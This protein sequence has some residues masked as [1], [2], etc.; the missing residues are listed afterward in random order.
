MAARP[1]LPV[2]TPLGELQ[3]VLEEEVLRVEN[4]LLTIDEEVMQLLT[5]LDLVGDRLEDSDIVRRHVLRDHARFTS[6]EVEAAIGRCFALRSEMT[7][8]RLRLA[9]CRSWAKELRYWHSLMKAAAEQLEDHRPPDGT[10][11]EG[12]ARYRSASRQVFQTIDEERMRIARDMH[13]GPAQ[14]MSNLV[15][16][17]EILERMVDRE[18]E[19]AKAEVQSY[20]EAMKGVLD[21]TRQLIFDLRPMTLDD[22]GVIPTLRR[23]VNEFRDAE[24]VDGRLSVIGTERRLPPATEGALFRIVKEALVNVRKHA[25]AHRLDVLIN[26]QPRRV[27][28][29]IKDDGD[30]FDL[31]AVE[32]RLAREPHFGLIS[33]RERADL[34]R[35]QLEILSQV[36][37]G[38]E[39]RVTLPIES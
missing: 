11:E 3:L 30:G 15:L 36:G 37:R 23:L 6:A 32:A 20:K 31:A 33:M 13:D 16:R 19:R 12:L 38:T 4:A 18:P 7:L 2:A 9:H 5:A 24:G 35:G 26:L 21:E 22:L 34:E 10:L 17:A 14:S 1:V 8:A 29:V 25:R 27:S 28:A 39:V